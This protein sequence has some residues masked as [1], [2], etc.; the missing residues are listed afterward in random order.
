M[1]IDIQRLWGAWLCEFGG[2]MSLVERK[3]R[4]EAFLHGAQAV[5][6]YLNTGEEPMLKPDTRQCTLALVPKGENDNDN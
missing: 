6:H 3:V 5:L 4:R 2:Q 1:I